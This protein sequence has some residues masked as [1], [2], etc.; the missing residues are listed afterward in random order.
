[1]IQTDPSRGRLDLPDGSMAY[2]HW[3]A[4]EAPRLLFT[5]ANGFCASAYKQMLG[6]LAGR[7]DIIAMDLRGHGRSDLPAEP[8]THHSWDIYARDIAALVERLDRRPD[9]MAGHS[10]GASSSLM[11]AARLEDA[12]P[13]A[14]VEPVVLPAIVYAAYRT[15][16]RS[17]IQKRIGMG[18]QARRRSNGW[19]DRDSVAERYRERPAF[20]DW[21]HGVVEDYLEDGLTASGDGVRLSCDPHWEAANFEAQRHDLL[22]AARQAG[23]RAR[24]L[25]AARRST[26]MN[27][28]GL[29]GRVIAVDTLADAGH[30]APMTRPGAV[31]QWIAETAQRYD[32]LG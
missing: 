30:L 8:A 27:A 16:L 3:P 4:P 13:L 17:L 14:L 12:P 22:K 9:L 28:N 15:P 23:S 7:F 32:L 18:D 2:L 25:K 11:A 26:V 24:V 5:H 10:M 21:A 19:A 31:A 29:Q 6:A 1:M 20:A